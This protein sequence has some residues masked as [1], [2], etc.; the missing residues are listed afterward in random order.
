[1]NNIMSRIALWLLLP[2]FLGFGDGVV[3]AKV[4]GSKFGS[5]VNSTVTSLKITSTASAE[6]MCLGVTIYPPS[7]A[8]GAKEGV[9]QVVPLKKGLNYTDIAI[10]ERF[11]TGTFEAAMWR[12]KLTKQEIPASDAA[13]QRIG[14]K[15]TGMA[16]YLWGYLSEP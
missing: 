2:L 10:P 4:S 8:T 13:A 3:F 14:Y 15:L 1:M 7:S 11:K 5:E 6:G 16:S 12:K 9:S